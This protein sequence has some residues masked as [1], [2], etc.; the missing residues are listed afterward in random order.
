MEGNGRGT[1]E[2]PD[3]EGEEKKKRGAGQNAKMHHGKVEGRSWVLTMPSSSHV[4]A[5]LE[6]FCLTPTAV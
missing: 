5:V 2:R 4:S 3:Q 1:S 6:I